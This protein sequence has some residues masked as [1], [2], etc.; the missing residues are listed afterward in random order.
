V[1][2]VFDGWGYV[3][4]FSY[5]QATNTLTQEDTFAIPEAMDPAFAEGYG[6]LSV[7]EV[8]VDP[9]NPQYAYLSYYGG[10][11]RAI[12]IVED[13]ARCAAAGEDDFPC[14]LEVGGYLSPTGNDFWGIETRI[15][16]GETIIFASDRDTGLWIFRDP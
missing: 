12:E 1:S 7:H 3:R 13:A 6:D 5:N 10:G 4:L 11:V 9:L 16:N 2:A 14:L 8:A 15:I